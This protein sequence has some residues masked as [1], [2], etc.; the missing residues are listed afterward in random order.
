MFTVLLEGSGIIWQ[1]SGAG[2][3]PDVSICDLCYCTITVIAFYMYVMCVCYCSPV[4]N[5]CCG[6]SLQCVRFAGIWVP[7]TG[8]CSPKRRG[9]GSVSRGERPPLSPWRRWRA[10]R[11]KAPPRRSSRSRATACSSAAN[12]RRPWPATAKPLWVG[13]ELLRSHP[14]YMHISFSYIKC[15]CAFH[16]FGVST[17]TGR[18]F[19]RLEDFFLV[20]W[21]KSR[22]LNRVAFI[23][24]K[25]QGN[26]VKI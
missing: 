15:E 26:I 21:K 4:C 10:A 18:K 6:V 17:I 5:M 8:R 14:L 19:G 13:Q 22:L 25:I 11:R 7:G 24:L 2:Q 16:K 1:L 20:F 3:S 9:T 23:W 12:T